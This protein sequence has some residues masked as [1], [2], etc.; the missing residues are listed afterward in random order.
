MSY[1]ITQYVK[2]EKMIQMNV[3]TEQIETDRH[4]KQ[5]FGY[6]RGKVRGQGYIRSLGL[7]D[8]PY[9]I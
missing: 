9:Y 7:T 4:R 3:F 6:H 5:S 8:T 2:S 1:D